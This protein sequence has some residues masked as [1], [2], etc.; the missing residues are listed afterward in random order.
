MS[1][2]L[3]ANIENPDDFYQALI[4]MQRDLD[5]DQVSLMNARLILILANQIGDQDV[6]GEAMKLARGKGSA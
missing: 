4:D 5:E 3:K 6:L 2:N 1:L